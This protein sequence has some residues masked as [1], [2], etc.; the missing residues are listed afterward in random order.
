MKAHF[1]ILIIIS[2]LNVSF[3]ASAQNVTFTKVWEKVYG[4]FDHDQSD[5]AHLMYL[6]N[7]SNI[8]VALTA[9][10]NVSGNKL[11]PNCQ[12]LVPLSPDMWLIKLD[13]N[14][15][16]IFDQSY[17]SSRDEG[18]KDFLMLNDGSML[19]AGLSNSPVEC[20]KSQGHYGSWLDNDIWVIKVDSAGFKIWDK[21][22]GTT[23]SDALNSIVAT[24]DSGFILTGYGYS[25]TTGNLAGLSHGSTDIRV[26]K[27]DKNGNIVWHNLYGGDGTESPG[28]IIRTSSGNYLIAGITHTS[29]ASGNISQ[30]NLGGPTSV[31]MDN[32]II[33]ID[34]GGALLWERRYGCPLDDSGGAPLENSKGEIVVASH[35]KGS[36]A[37]GDATDTMDRG[38][39]D[40]WIF[41]LDSATGNI[42]YDKRIGG[43]KNEWVTQLLQTSDGGYLL[44][45]ISTSDAGFDKSEPKWDVSGAGGDFWI[46]KTDS[47]FNIQWDKTIGGTWNEK[48]PHIIMINDST[49]ILGG[50]SDSFIGGDKTVAKFDTAGGAGGDLWIM[51]YTTS[52]ITGINELSQ[53]QFS[54]YPNPVKDVLYVSP[55]KRLQ[56]NMV[57]NVMD[58]QGRIIKEEKISNSNGSVIPINVS[59]LSQGVYLLR[60]NGQVQRFV[61]IV[62]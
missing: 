35:I 49:L 23:A 1:K 27:I 40:I 57:I 22:F 11:S 30:D 61:K 12:G 47:L 2:F 16:K 51:K 26:F 32:W 46:V 50:T 10:S 17:G 4:G 48:I 15:N 33:R 5:N 39:A 54:I 53:P 52:S 28:L 42:L 59:A 38:Q 60:M 21:R 56:A 31:K 19:L 25:S 37:G 62:P 58:M 9:V 18:V 3:C 44:A 43:N 14:G 34:E 8:V 7:D 41:A 55:K 29:I 36:C 45:C 6:D 13:Q 24:P 20:F